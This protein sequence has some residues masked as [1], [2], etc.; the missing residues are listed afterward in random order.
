MKTKTNMN[1]AFTQ[2]TKC[3][4]GAAFVF[5]L[6]AATLADAQLTPSDDAYVNSAAPTTNYGAATTLNLQ[7]AADTTFIRFDLTAVPSGYTGSSIAKATLKLYM[8]SVTT[9][10]SLNVDYVTGTWAENKITYNMQPTIGTTIAASVPLATANKAKYVEID[11]TAALVA[12]LNGT[13]PN[14][15]IA[16]V[17]NSPLVAT[18]DSKENTSASHPPELDIVYA[19]IAGVTTASGSGLTGGGSSGTL[20]LSMLTSCASKQVMQWNGSAWA[21]SNAGTGTITGVTAGTDLTG[22]G[23]SG[24]V[25]LNLDTTKVPQLNAANSFSGNQSI[26]GNLSATGSFT[27]QTASFSANDTTQVINVTQS[28]SGVAVAASSPGN[29]PAIFGSVTTNASGVGIAGQTAGTNGIGVSGSATS[30]SSGAKALG[31]YGSSSAPNGA[32]VFGQ[33]SDATAAGIGVAGVSGSPDGFGLY[34]AENGGLGVGVYGRWQ[35]GSSNFAGAQIG[36]WGDSSQGTGILGTS[37]SITGVFGESISGQGV[38]GFSSTSTAVYGDSD[39]DLGM[40]GFAGSSLAVGGVEGVIF[41]NSNTGLGFT[42]FGV[43]GDTSLSGGIGVV[44][45]ADDGNALWG[46]NNTVNHETLYAENDSGF[47]GGKTPLAARFAGPGASTYCYI[48]RDTNDNG[49]GD[50]VCTGSKSAA[51]PVDGNRMVRLYAVEAA[52]NWFEDA[53]SGRLSNG[54]AIVRFDPAFSQTINPNVE[55]HV[56]LTPKGVCTG[57]YVSDE[58]AD[59]FEVHEQ[60]GGNSNIAFD[61]RIMARRKGFESVRMQDV[62]ADFVQMKRESDV[63]ATKLEAGKAAERARPMPRLSRPSKAAPSRSLP[64]AVTQAPENKK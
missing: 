54:V 17:A 26:T 43:W 10:G 20:N 34:A 30:T 49:T 12:W 18:F 60:P 40:Y 45:T 14:D 61:Y 5:I 28:G 47:S 3:S 44:G 32:G 36:V 58:R 8:N 24:A 48:P 31:V 7:S 22:G 6:L 51:V 19:G 39:N 29:A 9:A 56:F 1:V 16:L 25:T 33:S 37:D 55:Y 41:A 52:D 64:L 4:L 42:T 11:I 21:C 62:T 57:L 35:S 15:G 13:Q 50:L 38:S 46:K 53:G 2:T 27:G 59:G 63:L 23:K